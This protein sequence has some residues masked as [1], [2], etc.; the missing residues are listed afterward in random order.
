MATIE[1][2]LNT[3][4][5]ITAEAFDTPGGASAIEAAQAI[6]DQW[7]LNS[8]DPDY[9][10]NEITTPAWDKSVS[11]RALSTIAIVVNP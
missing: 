10:I 8:S 6:T 7:I 11:F 3:G 1:I 5:S 4:M 9:I 2:Y